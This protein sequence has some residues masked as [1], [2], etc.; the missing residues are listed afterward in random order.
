MHHQNHPKKA[1][2]KQMKPVLSFTLFTLVVLSACALM[3]NA[4]NVMT[5]T[6]ANFDELTSDGPW[7]VKFYAPW[8]GHCKRLA[9]IFEDAAAKLD[10][11]VRLGKVD[12]T[13]ESGL[14]SR[15]GI[16]GYPTVNFIRGTQTKQYS[17]GR[18]VE[19]IVQYC[20]SMSGPASKEIDASTL[21]AFKSGP[22][23]KFVYIGD[24]DEDNRVF[25]GVAETY[26]GGNLEFAH[27]SD[28]SV[29]KA[30][31]VAEGTNLVAVT[32]EGNHA[33]EGSLNTESIDKFVKTYEEGE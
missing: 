2:K 3:S 32:D 29:A 16:R 27:T 28:K 10:G 19:A 7:L 25:V 1:K 18:S 5:L 22:K 11:K 9:P 4:E 26:Q 14:A 31:G 12:C 20:E 33:M 13:V 23:N 30:L 17:G 6:D 24:D 15:F 8:C 21:D